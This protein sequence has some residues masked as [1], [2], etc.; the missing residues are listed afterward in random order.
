[1]ATI[2]G[3]V[4]R[5][6]AKPS[7]PS[8]ATKKKYRLVKVGIRHG[9][10]EEEVWRP[11][12]KEGRVTIPEGSK[13][14]YIRQDQTLPA[15]RVQIALAR[16]QEAREIRAKIERVQTDTTG[17]RTALV[18]PGGIS[19][20]EAAQIGLVASQEKI[21]GTVPEGLRTT[22]G[23]LVISESDLQARQ[24]KIRLPFGVQPTEK[25]LRGEEIGGG[26]GFLYSFPFFTKQARIVTEVTAPAITKYLSTKSRSVSIMA[27]AYRKTVPARYI[28]MKV[29]TGEDILPKAVTSFFT[30]LPLTLATAPFFKTAMAQVDEPIIEFAKRRARG[31]TQTITKAQTKAAESALSKIEKGYKVGGVKGTVKEIAKI[32]KELKSKGATESQILKEAQGLLEVARMKGLLPEIIR[33]PSVRV[34]PTPGVDIASI[35]RVARLERVGEI[36]AAFLGTS[37]KSKD[38]T[39]SM[40][41]VNL[42]Q[43][44]PPMTIPITTQDEDV[45]TKTTT[46]T[47][48]LAITIPKVKEISLQLPKTITT[49]IGMPRWISRLTSKKIADPFLFD[50]NFRAKR[51][52]KKKGKQ[53]G[54]QRNLLL[55]EGFTEKFL[56]FK[57]VKV[58]SLK[59]ALKIARDPVGFRR[60]PIIKINRRFK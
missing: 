60:A 38:I 10:K 20:V 14:Q 36:T 53:A 42:R 13:L 6:G 8:E 3:A 11:V 37:I 28:A 40:L 18:L 41:D 39:A 48:T 24:P 5:P 21:R 58:T 49:T 2:Y 47:A 33:V 34:S 56:K 15:Q 55:A 16:A 19:M 9:R 29:E 26:V 25:A 22:K 46:R 50:F 27:E 52:K 17:Q 30:Y 43:T 45:V 4:S 35:F 31:A 57:P 7:E 23:F 59:Q 1:M 32:L 12:S 44:Q 54:R 51:A